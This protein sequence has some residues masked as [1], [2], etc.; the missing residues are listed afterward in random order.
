[1]YQKLFCYTIVAIAVFL[2]SG[3]P[4]FISLMFCGGDKADPYPKQTSA[5]PGA[6]FFIIM[7]LLGVGM[8][9]L[10]ARNLRADEVLAKRQL[11]VGFSFLMGSWMLLELYWKLTF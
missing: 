11:Y 6:M 8:I 7:G 9:M 4:A 5:T 1:V 3:M 10:S 2:I